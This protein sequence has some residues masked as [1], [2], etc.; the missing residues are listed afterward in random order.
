MDDPKDIKF[1]RDF[2]CTIAFKAAPELRN[3]LKIDEVAFRRMA[4]SA[5]HDP[6]PAF[7]Y[8]VLDEVQ[9]AGICI[10]DWFETLKDQTS[11]PNADDHMTRLQA[12]WLL[13]EENFRARKLTEVLVD[14]I[15][16]SRTNEPEY[17]RDYL[18]LR[19][20]DAT[21][22]SLIDQD[23]FFC[24]R[25]RNSEFSVQWAVRDI[26]AE[27]AKLDVSKRWYLK[28]PEPF[29]E[30]W[31]TRGV[32]FSSFRQRYIRSLELALP[33]ELGVLGK[34]YIHAYGSMSSDVHFTPQETSWNFDPDAVYLG[35]N[36]VGLLCLAIV[37]RCQ[38]LLGVVPEGSNAELRSIHDEN[39]G[40]AEIVGQLK[41]EKAAVGDFVWANGDI[42]E[43]I[44]IGRSKLGYVRYLLRYIERPPIPEI[45]EDWFAGFEIHLIAKRSAAERTLR[46]LQTDPNI[47]EQ[48]RAHFCNMAGDRHKKLLDQAVAILWRSVQRMK[49][50]NAAAKY[51]VE[52]PDE[53]S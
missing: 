2:Y 41:Q 32:E 6:R 8:R 43:V 39:T 10:H 35:F 3:A 13:D 7:I 5:W 31:K 28:H 25:R 37:I 48:T 18:Q 42:C 36:R 53:D 11:P 27:E 45:T 12:Q 52:K 47:D 23:E 14:L 19:A 33:N 24:F 51:V 29:Q 38:L 15:C 34:T 21:V 17:Y 46:R 44:E 22:R 30:K 49:T 9:K 4:P 40:P 50:P 20:L 1:D 26:V 16:F